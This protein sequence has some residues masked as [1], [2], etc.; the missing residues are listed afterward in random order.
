M[1]QGVVPCGLS[2]GSGFLGIGLQEVLHQLPHRRVHGLEAD[3]SFHHLHAK[4]LSGTQAQGLAHLG[5]QGDLE[6]GA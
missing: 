1:A 6:I 4:P 3:F 2:Q 5:G